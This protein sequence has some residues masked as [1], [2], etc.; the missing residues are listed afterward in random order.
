MEGY[1][2]RTGVYY[3]LPGVREV[4]QWTGNPQTIITD[5]ARMNDIDVPVA[6]LP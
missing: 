3:K 4:K 5:R 1:D 2:R 6:L